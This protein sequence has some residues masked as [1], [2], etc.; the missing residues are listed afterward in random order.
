MIRNGFLT[1][2]VMGLAGCS[3]GTP[4]CG[5]ER[6][7][8]L[9]Q[10]AVDEA[11]SSASILAPMEFVQ[12]LTAKFTSIRTLRHDND[13]DSYACESTLEVLYKGE[14]K[15]A[16]TIQYEIYP[17]QGSDSPV[18]LRYDRV[19][20]ASTLSASAKQADAEEEHAKEQQAESVA[21]ERRD[22]MLASLPPDEPSALNHAEQMVAAALQSNVMIQVPAS[23]TEVTYS[24]AGS[25][26]PLSEGGPFFAGAYPDWNI[27]C[28][29]QNGQLECV[30]ARRDE[31]WVH[32]VPSIG[33]SCDDASDGLIRTRLSAS[34]L[35]SILPYLSVKDTLGALEFGSCA[36]GICYKQLKPIGLIQ[37]QMQEWLSKRC[38][39]QFTAKCLE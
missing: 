6:A 23:G 8:E 29:P 33:V 15:Q 26:Q 27:I 35:R 28:E 24:I 36:D 20:I 19:A 13:L 10:K 34:E 39:T 4:N 31:N 16:R 30:T 38:G 32:C 1:I 25:R 22:A 14:V 7:I 37:P 2:A 9:L 17:V 3:S 5:D 21:R 11:R 12:Q 18:E